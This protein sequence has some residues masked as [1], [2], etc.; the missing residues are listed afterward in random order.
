VIDREGALNVKVLK[1]ILAS[2]AAALLALAPAA[3]M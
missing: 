1:Y 2:A 3:R